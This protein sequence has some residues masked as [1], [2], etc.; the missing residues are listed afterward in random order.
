MKKFASNLANIF[1]V[2][3]LIVFFFAKHLH[4]K[5]RQQLQI[6]KQNRTFASEKILFRQNVKHLSKNFFVQNLIKIL[7]KQKLVFYEMSSMFQIDPEEFLVRKRQIL[8]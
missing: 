7:E 5:Y 2:P 8:N 3:R 1:F 6:L 4:T